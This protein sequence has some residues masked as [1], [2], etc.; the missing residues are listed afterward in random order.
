[1]RIR[2]RDGSTVEVDD[3]YVLR[4][5]EAFVI[6]LNMLDSKRRVSMIHDS[7]GQPAGSRPGYLLRD[8][9]PA[10]REL[11]EA[12]RQYKADI[13]E[14]WRS[15]RWQD[16]PAKPQPPPPPSSGNRE[17]DLAAAH[18]QYRADLEQRWR[19]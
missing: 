14:R 4:D 5:G 11:E 12:R 7:R 2:R 6:P 19:G 9:G 8:D 15:N 10:E 1:M 16:V 18:Q 3:A 13:S 17:A